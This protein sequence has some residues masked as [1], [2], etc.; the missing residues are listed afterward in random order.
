MH[1]AIV[2]AVA[3]DLDRAQ[4]FADGV[5]QADN[6]RPFTFGGRLVLSGLP[7]DAFASPGDRAF[8]RRFC[9]VLE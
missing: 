7:A 8:D 5:V 9:R 4:S 6:G 2:N 1:I 3:G